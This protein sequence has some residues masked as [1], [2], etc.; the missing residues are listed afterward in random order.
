V[1][2]TA[3]AVVCMLSVSPTHGGECRMGRA[4]LAIIVSNCQKQLKNCFD[5]CLPWRDE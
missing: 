5:E 3:I 1:T 2:V 4:N